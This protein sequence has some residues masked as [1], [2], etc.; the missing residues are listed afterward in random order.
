MTFTG[1]LQGAKPIYSWGCE[2]LNNLVKKISIIAIS[3]ELPNF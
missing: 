1:P 3:E 2:C